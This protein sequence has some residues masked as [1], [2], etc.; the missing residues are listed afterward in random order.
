MGDRQLAGIVVHGFLEDAPT[1]LSRLRERLDEE[2]AD[3]FRSQAHTLRGASATVAADGLRA[4]AE[5]MELAGKAGQLDQCAELL[6]RA[7]QEF[8]LY[9]S[10]LERAGWV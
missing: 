2:D 1:Q 3:G 4:I 10:T 9:K 7:V 8:Q 5:A 6:P